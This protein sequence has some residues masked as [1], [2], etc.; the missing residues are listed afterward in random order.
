[1]KSATGVQQLEPSVLQV[2]VDSVSGMEGAG[3]SSSS[4]TSVPRDEAGEKPSLI[5]ICLIP[6]KGPCSCGERDCALERH[7][8]VGVPPMADQ[9]SR[10]DAGVQSSTSMRGV[11]CV[12]SWCLGLEVLACWGGGVPAPL[13]CCSCL[14]VGGGGDF[15]PLSLPGTTGGVP[16]G[17]RHPPARR[18]WMVPSDVPL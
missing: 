6:H 2:I 9:R 8:V 13:G 10:L 18:C 15:S 14:S 16:S 17:R 11:A 7:R 3:H 5:S 12:L 4:L 1:M